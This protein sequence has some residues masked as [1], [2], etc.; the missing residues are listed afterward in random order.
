MSLYKN[1]LT[2]WSKQD[3]SENQLFFLHQLRLA[4]LGIFENRGYIL[5]TSVKDFFQIKRGRPLF[6]VLIAQDVFFLVLIND[7]LYFRM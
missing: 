4:C 6:E 2:S 5:G 3:R 1:L 7:E